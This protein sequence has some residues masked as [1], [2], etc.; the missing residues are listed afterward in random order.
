MAYFGFG[1]GITISLLGSKAGLGLELTLAI[2]IS[3]MV[4]FLIV[5][6]TSLEK[7]KRVLFKKDEEAKI[8]K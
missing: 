3:S 1:V 6:F 4:F 2:V 7:I 5:V 8:I